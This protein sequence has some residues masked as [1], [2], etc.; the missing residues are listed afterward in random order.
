MRVALAL[1]LIGTAYAAKTCRET[2]QAGDNVDGNDTFGMCENKDG[3]SGRANMSRLDSEGEDF[4]TCCAQDA[5]ASL[6]K[7]LRSRLDS[8]KKALDNVTQEKAKGA[9]QCASQ[10]AAEDQMRKRIKE[11]IE[12]FEGAYA[13]ANAA[14]QKAQRNANEATRKKDSATR[15]LNNL[16]KMHSAVSTA[17][18]RSRTKSAASLQKVSKALNAVQQTH[19]DQRA[20]AQSFLQVQD[21]LGTADSAA[22]AYESSSGALVEILEN[23]KTKTEN[24]M[25]E[26]T[27]NNVRTT[28]EVDM[29][30]NQA[31]MDIAAFKEEAAS[32]NGEVAEEGSTA[33]D[34]KNNAAAQNEKLDTLNEETKDR[35][36]YCQQQEIAHDKRIKIS[37]KT[38]A[39]LNGGLQALS[40]SS[41]Q[42]IQ[43]KSTPARALSVLQGLGQDLNLPDVQSLMQTA[44]ASS[45]NGVLNMIMGLKD[46]LEKKISELNKQNAFCNTQ[47][48]NNESA[49]KG[50]KKQ[51]DAAA[52]KKSS[53]EQAQ[54][55]AESDRKEQEAELQAKEEERSNEA[56]D[57]ATAVTE[58]THQIGEANTLI[59]SVKGAMSAVA[60]MPTLTQIFTKFV[61]DEEAN[62]EKLEETKAQTMADEKDAKNRFAVLK[63]KLSAQIEVSKK[64]AGAAQAAASDAANALGEH[65]EGIKEQ[66]AIY[67]KLKPL[68]VTPTVDHAAEMAKMQSEI[69]SCQ[70]ALAILEDDVAGVGR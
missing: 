34:A 5:N 64:R 53:A 52:N 2:L 19:R 41:G 55:K 67:A 54:Q 45:V 60:D 3:Y 22:N 68:C 12:K 65:N 59:D 24:E 16:Q 39:D 26:A 56:K 32:F 6:V 14:M 37:E 29:G 61:A 35:Q 13:G 70:T 17:F 10:K 4:Q 63:S 51:A 7:V 30:I 20:V 57:N 25:S 66:D 28:G 58:L 8:E 31:Q 21:D 23:I 48:A 69:D 1:L 18:G 33:A 43:M 36:H 40:A 47:L 42:F 49:L 27:K 44:K 11:Q 38:I 9:A 62:R 15:N 50:L 46:D